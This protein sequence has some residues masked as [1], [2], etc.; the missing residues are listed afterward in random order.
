[1]SAVRSIL[2]GKAAAKLELKKGHRFLAKFSDDL[3]A[4]ITSEQTLTEQ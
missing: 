4:E 3:K 2:T 1:V